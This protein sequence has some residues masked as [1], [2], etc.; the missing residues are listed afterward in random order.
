MKLPIY[1]HGEF[2]ASVTVENK[3][4]RYRVTVTNIQFEEYSL[5]DYMTNRHGELNKI[6]QS[7]LPIID[8]HLT[9]VF[10]ANEKSTD[11]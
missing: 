3:P 5:Y 7:H 11:W 9:F 4:D 2:S 10:T 1:M 8:K 6:S